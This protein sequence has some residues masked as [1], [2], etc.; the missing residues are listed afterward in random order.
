MSLHLRR[1]LENL[2]RQI[3]LHAGRVEQLVDEAV[4]ALCDHRYEL[5]S[6]IFSEDDVV[7]RDEVRLEEECLKVLALHQPVA[8][9]L[10]RITTILKINVDLERI[11]DLGCNIAERAD[12]L[13]SY[14][15]FPMPE[16]L[17]AMA[18]NACSMLRLGLDAFVK[19][20]TAK[21][22]SVM[23]MEARV[24]QQNR[25]V[26]Q[27]L[28]GLISQDTSQVEPA[29]HVFSAARNIE[30]IADLAENIAEE[31]IYMIDGEIIRHKFSHL[32]KQRHE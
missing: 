6:R 18:E 9:D 8:S 14:P 16:D 2:N 29:L 24:D 23:R 26:I 17:S 10:R 19:S 12:C 28:S 1:D 32:D 21:A 27:E 7:D 15:Y 5:V 4:K 30:Q 13:Q 22:M 31:I 3:L 20:D 25:A 11:A